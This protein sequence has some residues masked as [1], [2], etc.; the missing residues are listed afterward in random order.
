VR[1]APIFAATLMTLAQ[2]PRLQHRHRNWVNAALAYF[3]TPDDAVSEEKNGPYGYLDDNFVSAYVL[4][5]IAR[6][7]GWTL[8]E[9][10][11]IG[12]RAASE[13]A[14]DI[15]DRER[16]LLGDLGEQALLVAGVLERRADAWETG[17]ESHP[18]GLT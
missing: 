6:D 8:I 2:D 13:V 18:I 15:L 17:T 12:E 10:A 1:W 9:E 16:E 11:W 4:K 7:V 5:Q 3:V 14:V